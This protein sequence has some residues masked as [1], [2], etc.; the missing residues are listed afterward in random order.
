MDGMSILYDYH[1][2]TRFSSD[3]QASMEEMCEAAIQL[4]LREICFTEHVDWVP[5]DT[6]AGY[7]KPEAYIPE[8][9]RCQKVYAGRLSIRIGVEI[10]EPH[11]IPGRVDDLFRAWPL[12]FALG[13]AHWIDDSG[14]YL[15]ETY[16]LHPADHVE[17]E[18]FKRVLELVSVGEFDSL[19][20]MDL[21]RR[22]RP[23]RLG[24]FESDEYADVI[25][26]I[27]KALI[28]RDRAFEINTSPLRRGLEATCPD[29][30]VLQWY[31]ELGGEKI[32]VGSDA[33]QPDH[34]GTGFEV[35]FDMLR[36]AGFS[37]IVRYERR[38]PQWVSI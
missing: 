24:P 28:E 26:A 11:L 4:G 37:R 12:D 30:T 14:V 5:W 33:H 13:S 21:V 3:G 10:S 2:H 17:T 1:T 20:H 27:L 36:A 8:T 15:S 7:F 23:T 35:A 6:T 32:T 16:D 29:L 18:Y 31:K 22:Y 38:Q 19:G 25:R 34:V 9:Q